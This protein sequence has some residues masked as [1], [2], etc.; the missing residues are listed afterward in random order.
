[1]TEFNFLE[2]VAT[3]KV[4]PE[5]VAYAKEKY[6]KELEKRNEKKAENEAFFQKILDS[7]APNETTT[8]PDV[9]ELLGVN[10]SKATYLLRML[11]EMGDFVGEYPASATNKR[12]LKVYTRQ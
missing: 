9:A 4:T 1:M 8:S 2:A 3:E 10:S 6:E 5:V 7:V 11:C 12:P